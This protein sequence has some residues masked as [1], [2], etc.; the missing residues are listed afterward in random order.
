MNTA[1]STILQV[2]IAKQT[3]GEHVYTG[4]SLCTRRT[5]TVMRIR[6]TTSVDIC[7]NCHFQLTRTW[8]WLIL[9]WNSIFC[10]P[11]RFSSWISVRAPPPSSSWWGAAVCLGQCS[12]ICWDRFRGRR[13][14]GWFLPVS[15]A[16]CEE[17]MSC[18]IERG[19]GVR[20][21]LLFLRSEPDSL[22]A[23][24]PLSLGE[25]FGREAK[26]FSAVT[27]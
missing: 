19:G 25:R 22:T 5:A 9:F 3:E 1:R 18:Y 7:A 21:H 11:P 15:K 23:A 8:L 27:K 2:Q 6:F 16:L 12:W 24:E 17:E 14:R 10:V 4:A 20:L 26:L 13:R